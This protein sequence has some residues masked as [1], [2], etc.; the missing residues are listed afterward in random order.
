MTALQCLN[1]PVVHE[2]TTW[3]VCRCLGGGGQQSV[4]GPVSSGEAASSVSGGEDRAVQSPDPAAGE[5]GKPT[6]P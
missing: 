6:D 4:R 2:L 5:R 1:V 3:R